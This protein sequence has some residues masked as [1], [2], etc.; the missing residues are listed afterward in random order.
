MHGESRSS[1]GLISESNKN[2]TKIIIN[3]SYEPFLSQHLYYIAETKWLELEEGNIQR[4]SLTLF[5]GG[6]QLPLRQ[7][8]SHLSEMLFRLMIFDK[9]REL[10]W[11]YVAGRW[12]TQ[13]TSI[14]K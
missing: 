2:V 10:V 5:S 13:D 4:V 7:V 11:P 12:A 6:K 9:F 8:V 3:N 14:P 1:L